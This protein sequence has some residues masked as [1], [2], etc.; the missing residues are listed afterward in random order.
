[1]R[2]VVSLASRQPH[3]AMASSQDQPV[4][5]PLVVGE[6]SGR[7]RLAVRL[8]GVSPDSIQTAEE[9]GMEMQR[10]DLRDR[11]WIRRERQL[12]LLLPAGLGPLITLVLW[13]V[14]A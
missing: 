1:M 14:F 10:E 9:I 5:D 7:G 3:P 8:F 2:R 6:G 4:G 11:R 13:H 12:R